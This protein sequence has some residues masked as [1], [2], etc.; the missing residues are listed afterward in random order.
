MAS[1]PFHKLTLR[2]FA[3]QTEFLTVVREAVLFLASPHAALS[4][5][6][7]ET[8]T[9]GYHG[10]RITV[11]EL[12]VSRQCKI[13]DFFQRV[14]EANGPERMLLELDERMDD[15]C[16]L[17]MRFDKDRV[18]M[19]MKMA[20]KGDPEGM[21]MAYRLSRGENVIKAVLKVRAYPARKSAAV[22]TLKTLI[23]DI[24]GS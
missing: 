14:I 18:V 22:E 11:L 10:N 21:N 4:E 17:H 6:L 5:N 15:D 24:G 8:T 12:E 13:R 19:G 20:E 3:H 7:K 9:E 23:K 1:L 16:Q 2:A